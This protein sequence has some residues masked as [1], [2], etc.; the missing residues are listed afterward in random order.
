[1]HEAEVNALAAAWVLYWKSPEGS[2]ARAELSH[3]S[4]R[5]WDLT[6]EDPDGAWQLILAIDRAE[7][8]SAIREVLSAGPLEDLLCNHGEAI[9]ERVEH[10]AKVNP[11]FARL[12]GGVWQRRM[13]ESLWSRVQAVWDRSGWDGNPEQDIQRLPPPTNVA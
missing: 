1:M 2:A 3:A 7:P 4:D 12:L 5:V 8:S 13:S 10:E 11:S 6:H 9:I